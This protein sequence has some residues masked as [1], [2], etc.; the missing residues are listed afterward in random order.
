[1]RALVLFLFLPMFAYGADMKDL[2]GA[3]KLLDDAMAS[4]SREDLP[5]AFSKLKPY[6]VKLPDGEF[7]VMIGRMAD[8]HRNLA[9]RFGKSLG[10][11]F[12]SQK[13]VAD[14]AAYFL[15]VEKFER[16][17]VRWH[18]YLYHPKD[19]WQMNSVFFDDQIQG[20]F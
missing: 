8:Q 5:G 17:L 3:R 7:D 12:V 20:L 1:M 4:V 19:R 14:T 13:A 10:S 18:F 11:Q 2:S 16:H 15:Y 9:P 6:W